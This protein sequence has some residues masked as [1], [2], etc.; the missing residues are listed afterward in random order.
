MNLVE[1]IKVKQ[2]D[3]YLVDNVIA[4]GVLA[5]TVLMSKGDIVIGEKHK[6]ETINILI[7]GELKVLVNGEV[8]HIKAPYMV[9]SKANTR[10]IAYIIEDTVWTSI[11]RV[12]S[13]N[14]DDIEDEVIIKTSNE[15]LVKELNKLDSKI[16]NNIQIINLTNTLQQCV[17]FTAFDS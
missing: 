8:K 5:R 10:K 12:T 16:K 2:R 6:E 17:L 13:T 15:D 4:D 9:K 14:L 7:R 3:D 11:H 1:N